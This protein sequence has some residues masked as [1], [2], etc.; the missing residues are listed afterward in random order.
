MI[1]VPHMHSEVLAD[2]ARSVALFALAQ[3][4][5]G[6]KWARHYH[7]IVRQFGWSPRRNAIL[8]R[9][10]NTEEEAWLASGEIFHG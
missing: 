8:G 4:P 5:D 1:Y 9:P 7:G 3:W 6:L 2:Q 10:S